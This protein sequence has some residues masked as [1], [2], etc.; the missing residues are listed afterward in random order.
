MPKIGKRPR[1]TARKPCPSL[2][3]LFQ[4]HSLKVLSCVSSSTGVSNRTHDW[5][6]SPQQRAISRHPRRYKHRDRSC[7]KCSSRTLRRPRG[8]GIQ[9][10]PRGSSSCSLRLDGKSKGWR[11]MLRLWW[12]WLEFGR[13]RQR[14]VRFVLVSS[15]V[16]V[17][18]P[19]P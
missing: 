19:R 7:W 15:R 5:E 2:L 4:A 9:R 3:K 17:L 12:I 1:P 8:R 10:R 11:R 16:W 13:R 18:T 14:R 6:S